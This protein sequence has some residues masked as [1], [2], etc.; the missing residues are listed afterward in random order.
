MSLPVS[1]TVATQMLGLAYL[2]YVLKYPEVIAVSHEYL[3]QKM[4]AAVQT[5]LTM[6]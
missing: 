6:S 1:T 3:E 5:Y 4:G 2:R